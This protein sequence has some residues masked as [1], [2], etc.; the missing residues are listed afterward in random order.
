[1]PSPAS[2]DDWITLTVPGDVRVL[3]LVRRA[4][5]SVAQLAGLSKKAAYES[6]LAVS[7]ACANVIEHGYDSQPGH[8]LSVAC[9]PTE[10][11]LE[12]RIR[13]QGKPFD[14]S[15]VPHLPPDALREGGRGVFLIRQLMD[16][17]SSSSDAAGNEL[18]LFKRR[19][20]S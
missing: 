15:A 9:R 8:S 20:A 1:M 5:E 10:Q 4:V 17:V 16:E 11:G 2:H 13:D 12:V 6:V 14:L 3:A 19:Q 7:E 18:R